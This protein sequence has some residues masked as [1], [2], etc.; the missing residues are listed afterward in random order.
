MVSAL[1]ALD[2]GSDITN[3]C[4]CQKL[5]TDGRTLPCLDSLCGKCFREVCHLYSDNPAGMAA[6]P[7]CGDQFHLPSYSEALPDRSF[8]DTLVAL[9][10]IANQNMEENTCDSCKQLSASSE[11]VQAAEYY[12]IECRQRMCAG[13]ARPHPLCPSTKDHNVFGLGLDSANEVV[14]TLKSFSPVC[15]NHKDT[16][17]TI[18]C[19]QCNTGLCSQCKNVHSGHDVEVLTDDTYGQLTNMV[20][21]LCDNLHYQLDACKVETGRVQKLLCGVQNSIELMEKQVKDNREAVSAK[22][23]SYLSANAKAQKF[24]KE[25]LEKGSVEDMLLNHR[26][27]NNRVTRLRNMSCESSELDTLC[28]GASPASLIRDVC[29]SLKSKCK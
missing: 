25:L 22:F 13:C 20:K 3:C 7:Q 19:Y 27:L 6:C 17:A 24:A 16:C 10:K 8:I 5:A 12:C 9:K 26:L 11:P 4:K 2:E 23:S 14:H 18:H 15:A 21:L 1:K 28:K 29:T